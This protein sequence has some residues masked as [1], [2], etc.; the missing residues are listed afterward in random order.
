M[1]ERLMR[2]S[3]RKIASRSSVAGDIRLTLQR[4]GGQDYIFEVD[5]F[6]GTL[7]GAFFIGVEGLGQEEHF[8]IPYALGAD[9][10]FTKIL[11]RSEFKQLQ[12][13]LE[14]TLIAE[15]GQAFSLVVIAPELPSQDFEVAGI[16]FRNEAF[17]MFRAR[18]LY[19]F[20]QAMPR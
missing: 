19:L 8:R 18:P 11:P 7:A 9:I 4:D 6:E 17:G 15:D 20:V 14:R 10:D 3:L 12:I 2:G 1:L 13:A 16:H 5:L